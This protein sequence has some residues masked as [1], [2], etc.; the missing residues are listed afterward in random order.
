VVV[1]HSMV[2]ACYSDAVDNNCRDH[3]GPNKAGCPRIVAHRRAKGGIYLLYLRSCTFKYRYILYIPAAATAMI[4]QV[5]A[6]DCPGHWHGRWQHAQLGKSSKEGT[7]P[8]HRCR[9][10]QHTGGMH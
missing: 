6:R 1:I 7:Q 5:W 3:Q 9:A 8:P 10:V 4:Q 2:T